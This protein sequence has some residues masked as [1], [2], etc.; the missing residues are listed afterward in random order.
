[1][2]SDADQSDERHAAEGGSRMV[3]MRAREKETPPEIAGYLFERGLLALRWG[4]DRE[5]RGRAS[6]YF[7]M[8]V[9]I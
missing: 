3:R 7:V 4:E 1:M 9:R 2:P 6:K 5:G 8:S